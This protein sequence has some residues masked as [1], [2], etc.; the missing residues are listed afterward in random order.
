VDD[1]ATMLLRFNRLMHD[2]EVGLT[3]RNS[4]Y[5]WEIELLVDFQVCDFGPNRRRLIRRYQ[6]AVARALEHGASK[7]MKLSEYLARTRARS[8]RASAA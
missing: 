2:V 6:R 8:P 5:P 1:I 7:P 3:S 4:F